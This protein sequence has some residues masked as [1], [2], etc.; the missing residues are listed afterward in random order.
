VRSPHVL[1]KG[2]GQLLRHSFL[3]F[4]VSWGFITSHQIDFPSE[5]DSQLYSEDDDMG[6]MGDFVA[7]V[8]TAVYDFDP[9]LDTEMAIKSG[10]IVTV[11]A[12]ECAGWVSPPFIFVSLTLRDW[13]VTHGRGHFGIM[14]EP[15]LMR[16]VGATGPSRSSR[17]WTSDRRDGTRAGE[18]SQLGR[19]GRG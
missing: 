18:L 4:A 15:W 14:R 9:E 8:Y 3:L 16:F 17:G 6:E 19:T 7:G 5:D 2:S 13:L 1:P 11:I 10:E 12:R